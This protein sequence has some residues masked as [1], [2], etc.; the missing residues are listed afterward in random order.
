MT[1]RIVIINKNRLQIIGLYFVLLII[2]FCIVAPVLGATSDSSRVFNIRVGS[3]DLE[4]TIALTPNQV[5]SYSTDET[6]ASHKTSKGH[7]F[8][9]EHVNLTLPLSG[10]D[11]KGTMRTVSTTTIRAYWDNQYSSGG[12]VNSG[13]L[14]IKVNCH[15]YATG[16]N[17][18][19]NSMSYI[20]ADDYTSTTTRRE[21][22]LFSDSGH[23]VKVDSCDIG[24]WFDTLK[25]SEKNSESDIYKNSWTYTSPGGSMYKK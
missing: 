25:T 5:L 18:W 12:Y 9:H 8:A 10:Y 22:K 15:G 7:Y 17:T 3:D 20:L 14:D 4:V 6:C 11:Q 24:E 16:Y 1:K 21:C 19:I 2:Q 23:S 13:G